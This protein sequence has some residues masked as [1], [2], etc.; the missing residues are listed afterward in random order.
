MVGFK[1]R[2]LHPDRSPRHFYGAEIRRHR[3]LNGDMSLSRLAKIL[4]FSLGH[5][6]RIEGGESKPPEG[7]SE[8]LDVAFNTDGSFQ[9]YYALAR[10]EPFPD[11]YATFLKLADKA[12]GHASYTMTVPGLLQTEAFASAVLHAGEPFAT[13]EEIDDWLTTRMGRQTRVWRKPPPCR[14]WFIV[15]EWALR[16]PVGD[17]GVMVDQLSQLLAA[18]QLQHVTIQILSLGAGAHSE[19]GGSSLIL[20]TMSDQEVI[21]YEEGS[22]SG[23]LFDDTQDVLHR[24]GLYDLLRAQARSPKESETMIRSALEGFTNGTPRQTRPVA[25]E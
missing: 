21:A 16:R 7:L 11:K 2:E 22:R 25:D 17:A 4:G 18:A 19:L 9:R 10:K 8:A 24:Q 12:V 14:Y 23:R 3:K 5:L 20:L 6:S 15:D 13:P 1:E